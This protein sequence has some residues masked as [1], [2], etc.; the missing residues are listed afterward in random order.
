MCRL[1][2]GLGVAQ[3]ANIGL[4]CAVFEPVHGSAPDI[5]GQNKANPTALLMSAIE[6]LKYIGENSYADN[7]EKAL[8]KTLEKGIRTADL[9]GNASTSEFTDAII[10]EL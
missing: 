3:G 8:F 6:M 7:I 10:R 4:D 9:G 5:K 1:N 2:R